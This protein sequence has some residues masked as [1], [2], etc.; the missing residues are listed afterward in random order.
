EGVKFK[1]RNSKTSL[2]SWPYEDGPCTR[3]HADFAGPIDGRKF[4]VIMDAHSKWPEIMG[5][6]TT[7][8]AAT[9]TVYRRIFSQFGYPHALVTDN[10]MQIVS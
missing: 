9:I 7:T 4:L 10:G 5:M 2:C 8:S 6:S 3:I 1:L